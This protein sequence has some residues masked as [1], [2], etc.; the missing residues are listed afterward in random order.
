M[1]P[2]L[3]ES[4]AAEYGVVAAVRNAGGSVGVDEGL[5][6]PPEDPLG[7]GPVKVALAG[8]KAIHL[9]IASV[10][11]LLANNPCSTGNVKDLQKEKI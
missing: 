3:E 5:V 10:P 7:H 6:H 9:V 11:Q 1:F 2:H 8:V 4:C